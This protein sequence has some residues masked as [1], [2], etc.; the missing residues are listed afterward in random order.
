LFPTLAALAAENKRSEMHHIFGKTLQGMLFLTLPATAGLIVW[1]EP[2]IRLLFQRG[3]FDASSTQATVWALRFFAL[4]LVGH[5][6]IEIATRAFY[7]LKNTKTPVM[8]AL[9]TMGINV[10]LSV[11]LMNQFAAWNYPAHAGLALATSIAVILE[12]IILLMFLQPEMG[13]LVTSGFGQSLAKM[14]LATGGM[15]FVLLMLPAS[16]SN[17]MSVIGIGIGGAV[18]LGLAYLTGIK[19]ENFILPNS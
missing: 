16:D 8:I 13:G 9:I 14:G 1:G 10:I 3:E 17:L 12:M 15:V 11:W 5:A 19:I 4:G 6:I 7:A 2:I 18:Y